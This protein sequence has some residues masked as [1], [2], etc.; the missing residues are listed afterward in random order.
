MLLYKVVYVFLC[1][2][3]FPL[4]VSLYVLGWLLRRCVFVYITITLRMVVYLTLSNTRAT[5]CKKPTIKITLIPIPLAG[6]IEFVH[7]E[8]VELLYER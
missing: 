7:V 8:H 1:D 5:G 3:S 4:Y 6:T 2:G